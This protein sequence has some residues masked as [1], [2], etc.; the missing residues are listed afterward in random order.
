MFT[1][2]NPSKLLAA[3]SIIIRWRRVRIPQTNRN[4]R[5]RGLL[6]SCHEA[7]EWY[8]SCFLGSSCLQFVKDHYPEVVAQWIRQH[9]WFVTERCTHFYSGGWN[10]SM[11]PRCSYWLSP[12]LAQYWGGV[13]LCYGK[14]LWW[15]LPPPPKWQ[16]LGKKRL[17]S[18][19]GI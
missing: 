4:G 7:G 13:L 16:D 1:W 10:R 18:S 11:C 8:M 3:L 2:C 12:Q 15:C 17:L 5:R 9:W 19:L 6:A 14:W